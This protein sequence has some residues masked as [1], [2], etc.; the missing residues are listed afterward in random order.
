MALDAY[1]VCPCGSGKKFK[2]CCQPV[3]VDIDK[4]FQLE[5]D[6]Q[7]ESALKLMDEVAA[8]H[9]DNAEAW[10]RKAQLQ[11][12]NGQVEEAENTLQKA[13]DIN[14][15]YAFGHWLKAMFRQ[16][17]GE[18]HG[19]LLL[20]RK[21]ADLYDPEAKD[22]LAQIYALIAENE[23]KLNRPVAARAA[24]EM[25]VHFQPGNDNLRQDFETVFGEQSRL[26]RVA[27]QS[28]SFQSPTA[29]TDPARRQSWD[30]VV[31]QAKHGRLSEA[32][33][34]FEELT[35]QD[36]QDAAA[37]YNLGLARAWLGDNGRAVDAL[38]RYVQLEADEAKAGDAW[39]LAEVLL[40]GDG[41]EDRGDYAEHWALFEIRNGQQ[42][43]N[44][45]QQ[46]D[47]EGRLAGM[48]QDQSGVL[49]GLV[50]EKV[51]GLTPQHAASQL[52]HLGSYIILVGNQLRI[53]NTV[54]EL[55]RSVRDELQQGAGPALSPPRTGT[56]P[57][58]FVDVPG[59]AL[60][61]PVRMTDKQEAEKKV[62]E[63]LQQ[64]YEEK[65]I[66][67]ALRALDSTP[68]VDAAGHRVLR[69]KLRGVIHFIQD[70][71]AGGQ[72]QMY[73]FDR[74]RRKLGLSEGAAPA[75]AAAAGQS[76]DISAMSAAELA[77]LPLQTTSDDQLRQAFQTANRLDARDLAA[78]FAKEAVGRPPQ[79]DK[80]DRW[81]YYNHLIDTALAEGDNAAAI[82]WIEAGQKF[83]VEHNA[84]QRQNDFDL[85]LG[86]AL[87]KRASYE[88]SQAAFDRLIERAPSELR[89]RS[90]AATTM[91]SARQGGRAMHFA[92]AG[93]D[94]ARAQNDRDAEQNFMELVAAAKKQGG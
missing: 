54:P 70:C 7:H 51:T 34:V 81:F 65:W 75:A 46:W 44:F 69:K 14:P 28:W 88:E 20:L 4:A 63:Y 32:A 42:L 1:A 29:I 5:A 40:C 31:G 3:H 83:D 22:Y 12:Q 92:Q 41:L 93:L 25:A 47:R 71:A 77:G 17:E 33:R 24:L 53:W 61:F 79:S 89:Y 30:Q 57:A 80:A 64:Y 76:L 6:G 48:T 2:W 45:L 43:V 36:E 82:N 62:G 72:A 84:G 10:G 49:T 39:A 50:L 86:K 9:P 68:P 90:T 67:R 26:P 55:L 11:Y 38:D 15:G 16:S 87:A 27:R 73:D 21:A 56:S 74:L 35:K 91:L 66:H 94:K 37:W 18:I 19:A 85:V 78:R 23:L 58:H 52:P 13:F 60:V 59:E 8:R